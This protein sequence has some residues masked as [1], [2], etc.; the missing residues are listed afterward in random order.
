MKL[1]T[2]LFGATY[3]FRSVKDLLGRFRGSSARPF[4]ARRYG[5]GHHLGK[6]ARMDAKRERR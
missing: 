6:S 2:T 3:A 1:K 5:M 4:S